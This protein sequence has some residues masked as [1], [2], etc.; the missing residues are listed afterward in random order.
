MIDKTT[1]SIHYVGP[2]MKT[3]GLESCT[4][5]K[6]GKVRSGKVDLWFG[7]RKMAT[8]ALPK[9]RIA[10][11]YCQDCRAEQAKLMRL[12]RKAEAILASADT[13]IADAEAILAE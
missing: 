13:L 11:S 5:G 8:K 12:A 2:K 9:R 3:C 1:S 6:G 7:T 10:Q 4:N